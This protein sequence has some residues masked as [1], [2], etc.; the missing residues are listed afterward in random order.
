MELN[1]VVVMLIVESA[2]RCAV[3]FSIPGER[4][5]EGK[6]G[7]P[8]TLPYSGICICQRPRVRT[9]RKGEPSIPESEAKAPLREEKAVLTP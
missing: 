7:L 8:G 6:R 1:C 9:K 4:G 3:G 2:E 5:E